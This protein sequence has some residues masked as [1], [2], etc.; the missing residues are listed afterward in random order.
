MPLRKI[1]LL[2]FILASASSFAIDKL[3]SDYLVCYGKEDAPI[4]VVQYY[5]FT[6]PHCVALF[7]KQF[8]KIKENYIATGKLSWI[9]HPV[10]IDLLTV[11]AMDCLQKLSPR[12]KKI[13]LE[14][15]LEEVLVDNPK[16][17]TLFLQKA[18]EVLGKPLPNLQEKEYLS[19]TAAFQDAFHFLKHEEK[20]E[21]V[22]S[23]EINGTFFGGQVP[24]IAF[25]EKVLSEGR[26]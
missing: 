26:A 7:R 8:Q 19:D 15:I 1:L 11:Q 10:P 13:F 25:I 3:S 6:C 14:A 2:F 4:E 23:V 24:D 16:L 9:F 21:A 17:S 12:E 20:L 5:S 18:M 22:P